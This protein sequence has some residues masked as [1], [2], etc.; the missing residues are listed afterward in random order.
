MFLAIGIIFPF[1]TMNIPV[2][3]KMLLPM[4]VP[5]LLCGF[6]LGPSY[7]AL[8]GFITPLLRSFLF[9]AP[10]FYPHA[11]SMSFEL[12]V[13]G[14]TSGLVYHLVFK[15]D[16]KIMKIYI[17]LIIAMILGRISYGIVKVIMG[18]IESSVFTFEMFISYSLINAIPGIIFQ[19]IIIPLIIH[20]I[21]IKV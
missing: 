7:G 6:I 15:K 13:Y 1:I 9:G 10:I 17:S 19:L 11:V 18:L 2:V 20:L 14:F 8:I 12:L 21:K 16:N 4:H 5:I 3:G